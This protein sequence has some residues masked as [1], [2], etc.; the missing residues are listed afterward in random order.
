[1]LLVTDDLARRLESAEAIDAAGC[2]EAQ[3]HL[4]VNC[5]SAV[6]AIGG[7]VAVFC[8]ATSPLTHAVGMGMHGPVT[9]EDLDQLELFFKSRGAPVV[10]DV[11]P[12]SDP[13]LREQVS[14][15]GYRVVEFLNVMVR[16]TPETADGPA[17]AGIE[18]KPAK[19]EDQ[20]TYVR[21]VIGGFFG[22]EHLSEEET[23]LGTTLLH[24]PSSAAYLASIDGHPA[25]GGGLSIRNG[26]ASFFG[27][28]TLP[29]F[30]H[31]GV[32]AAI[33]GARIAHAMTSACKLIT[34]GTVPGSSSQRNYQRLGFQIAYTKTTMVLE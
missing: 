34:A 15:R 25:G 17:R 27:D 10:I 5:D 2:A 3:C 13:T 12:H 24:M 6:E 26:V 21:T 22:R 14:S 19:E 20:D 29:A 8:G 1:M 18:I 4:E 11:C 32:H 9:A 28:A 23:R 31:R 30:R 7:G 33:I 16:E